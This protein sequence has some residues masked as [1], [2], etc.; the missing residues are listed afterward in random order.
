MEVFDIPAYWPI[1]LVYFIT[2]FT[3]TMR[4]RVAHMIRY[5]YV[6]WSRG[7]KK[8]NDAPVKEYHEQEKPSHPSKSN[9]AD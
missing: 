1:L 5:R 7:G 9:H 3:V 6:P 2:L 4:D 8:Y